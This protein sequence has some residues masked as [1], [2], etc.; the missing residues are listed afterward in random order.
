M[1][2]GG[3]FDL[4]AK[5]ERLEEVNK[6]LEDPELW[7]DPKRAQELGRERAQL[8]AMVNVLKQQKQ[9][10]Q[11]LIDLATLADQEEDI[12]VILSLTEEINIIEKMIN[13][14]EFKRMFSGEMDSHNAYLD[15]Q[16]GSGGTE[17][18]DWANMLLRMY[19]RWAE[20][21]GFKVEITQVSPGEV[22]GIKGA[23]VKVSG[24]YAYGWLRTES[25]VHLLLLL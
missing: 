10:I 17:A 15:V 3:I 5:S 19:L 22:E 6:E 20:K 2:F 25:G 24:D 7:A 13:D 8:E 4:D 11:D 14:L 1:I 21:K 23:T 9:A 18:Q 12:S 16:S